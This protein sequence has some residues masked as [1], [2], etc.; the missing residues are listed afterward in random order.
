MI[1]KKVEWLFGIIFSGVGLIF[2][3]VGISIALNNINFRNN[4]LE[5]TAVISSIERYRDSDG[6]TRH[7]VYVRYTIDSREYEEHLNFYSSGM[8]EGKEI[9]IYYS[10]EQ[11]G[12]I[13]AKSSFPFFVFFFP[14]MGLA[15]AAIGFV[16]IFYKI[17]KIKNR[18]YLMENGELVYA[19]ITGVDYNRS[20]RVN[21][22]NPYVITC[23]WV[24]SSTG[25]F[26]FFTSENIWFDP[27]LVIYERDI[28]TLPVYI[29]RDNPKKY[30]VSL[31][32]LESMVANV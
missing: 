7:T 6:D 2:F 10:P 22:R 32:E 27:E 21:G 14:S 26:Y 1:A 17:K 15:F 16:F 13:L 29:D 20:Y 9:S 23:K 25:L 8:Y 24:D 30:A 19:E 31:E 28:K 11:P 3:I 4:A 12:R 18:K 5:T